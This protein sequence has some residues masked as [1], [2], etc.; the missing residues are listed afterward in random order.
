[1]E[2][3]VALTPSGLN[4]AAC[5]ALG[6]FHAPAFIVTVPARRGRVHFHGGGQS[7]S[8]P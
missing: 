4:A 2:A 3:V 1:M 8:E 5:A 6:G 7:R